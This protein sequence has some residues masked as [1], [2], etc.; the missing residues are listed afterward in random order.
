MAENLLTVMA[1]EE[2]DPSTFK[3]PHKMYVWYDNR[4]DAVVR[5]VVSS[6]MRDGKR[7][8]V[9]ELD[10]GALSS[11]P[12]AAE[13]PTHKPNTTT[14]RE[15]A[16]WCAEGNGQTMNHGTCYNFHT[17]SAKL[18]NSP[19]SDDVLVRRWAD[20]GWHKPTREYLCMVVG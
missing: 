15:L 8:W 5:N 16:S 6:Y 19:V 10:N 18:D 11:A 7:S 13:I 3:E 4:L 14:N 12:H 1:L 2:A 20:N 9:Y 17:Y